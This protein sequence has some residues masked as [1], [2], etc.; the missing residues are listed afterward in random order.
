MARDAGSI[1]TV[2]GII[3]NIIAIIVSISSFAKPRERRLRGPALFT[4][5]FLSVVLG[6]IAFNHLYGEDTATTYAIIACAYWGLYW[7]FFI[8]DD[9]ED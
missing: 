7:F 1:I 8:A 4:I 9:H 3:V 5:A 2:I 6:T